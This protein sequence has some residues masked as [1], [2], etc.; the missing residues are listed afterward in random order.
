M[1]RR[2]LEVLIAPDIDVADSGDREPA[3]LTFISSAHGALVKA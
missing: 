1:N 2:L 3:T